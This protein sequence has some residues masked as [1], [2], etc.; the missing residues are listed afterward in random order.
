MDYLQ[1]GIA[2]LTALYILITSIYLIF[3]FYQ[4]R[5]IITR[6]WRSDYSKV[7]FGHALSIQL[8]GCG[9]IAIQ[10]ILWPIPYIGYSPIKVFRGRK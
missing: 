2:T 8:V 9:V 3:V 4:G 10:T 1:F 6:R 7:G 5:A